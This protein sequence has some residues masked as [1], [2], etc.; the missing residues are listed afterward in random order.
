[1]ATYLYRLGHLCAR[2]R[3]TVFLLW[4]AILIGIALAAKAADGTTVESF[5][6][7]GT[8]SQKA[9]DLLAGRF[10]AQSGSTMRVVF[11][12]PEGRQLTTEE[13]TALGQAI[14]DVQFLPGVVPAAGFVQGQTPT[15]DQVL[16]LVTISPSQTIAFI[17]VRFDEP[18]QDV[19][20]ADVQRIMDTFTRAAPPIAKITYG[21]D[22]VN[23]A[24]AGEPPKSEAI[25]LGVA[26]IVLLFSFGSFVAMGLPL[27]TALIGVGIGSLAISLASAFIDVSSVA[28]TLAVMIGLAVGIDYAL[29]VVTRHRAFLAEG[30]DVA[31]SAARANATSGGAVVFAGVS[32]VIAIAGLMVAGIPFL[33]VMGFAAA[34]TVFI[35]VCIA[36]TLTPA[37]LALVGHG[38]DKWSLP[39][40]QSRAED[41]HEEAKGFSTRLARWAVQHPVPAL[42]AGLALIAVLAYPL[43]DLRLGLPDDGSKPKGSTQRQAYDTLARGF[44]PGFNGPLTLVVDL[45]GV[46][47]AQAFLTS[48]SGAVSADPNV[49][50]VSPAIP[51]AAGNTAIISVIP[52]TGPADGETTDL[53]HRL[54]DDV[55]PAVGQDAGSRVFV[56]GSTAINVDFSD[57]LGSALPIF[58]AVVILLTMVLLAIAFRSILIP[59]KAAIAILLSIGASFGVVVAVFQWGWFSGLIGVNEAVPIVSFLPLMMFAIL[60]GLSMDYEVFIISRIR[61]DYVR[62]G[63]HAHDAVL[64]GLTSSARVVTAAAIIMIS[65]FAAFVLGDDVIIKM[66]GIGLASAVFLDATVVRMV[67]VPAVMALLDSAAWWLPRWLDRVLPNLDVEGEQ[68]LQELEGEK[69]GGAHVQAPAQVVAS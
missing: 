20:P 47:D 63:G 37:L 39:G 59:I 29:F 62:N 52:K 30:L 13:A 36:V 19:D 28:P 53:V 5:D 6:L 44:G 23:A 61:E 43:L 58:M 56:T 16:S 3:G 33:T 27:V 41:S 34:F 64:S 7:P 1:M 55:L 67:I 46:A 49:A 66:F 26:V 42:V 45:D 31:E 2:R 32:V 51:N 8:E 48:I 10:P 21:G 69:G 22:V 25:G 57:K 4:M 50:M 40:V 60:F 17:E 68:L 35:A 54:R 12:V 18:A 15:R 11:E 38:I 9:A 14:V 24:A 65:V